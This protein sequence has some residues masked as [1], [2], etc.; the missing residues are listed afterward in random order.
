MRHSCAVGGRRAIRTKSCC[1]VSLQ[2]LAL[3]D[4]QVVAGTNFKLVLQTSS[5]NFEATVFS[6]SLPPLTAHGLLCASSRFVHLTLGLP[7]YRRIGVL[8]YVSGTVSAC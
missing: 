6:A 1:V 8:E 7:H 2:Q 3:A 5:G 4:L